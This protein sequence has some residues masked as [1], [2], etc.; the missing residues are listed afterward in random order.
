MTIVEPEVEDPEGCFDD[1]ITHVICCD[2]KLGERSFCG[3]EVTAE[4]PWGSTSV[5]C[6]DCFTKERSHWCPKYGKCHRA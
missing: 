3:I 4:G 5:K 1:D 2:F 6:I